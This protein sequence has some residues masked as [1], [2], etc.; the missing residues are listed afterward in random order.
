MILV[1]ELRDHGACYATIS[2]E[3]LR[4]VCHLRPGGA[5]AGFELPTIDGL[6][7][8]AVVRE[9]LAGRDLADT[10]DGYDIP[11]PIRCLW[12][13]ARGLP[14]WAATPLRPVGLAA[15]DVVYCHKRQQPG[16][17]T[18]HPRGRF[19]ITPTMARYTERRVPVP[20]TV[21]ETLEATCIGN[22]DE[23]AQLLERISS[24]G[25]R[26]NIGFNEVEGWSI[27]RLEDWSL[28]VD[29]RLSRSLPASAAKVLDTQGATA[30]IPIGWT[31]PAW[32][33]SLLLSGWPA[34]TPARAA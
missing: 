15:E 31:P 4:V 21:C 17:V 2:M 8:G 10:E 22:A 11:L 33:P 6:L 3:P 13:D 20:T 27:Q 16:T 32:K 28:V 23:V 26:R 34:G 25:K 5:V 9:A 7:A 29:G 12:R 30:C 1:P 14:L 24:L 19:V 18:A